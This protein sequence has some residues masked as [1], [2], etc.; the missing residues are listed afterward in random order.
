MIQNGIARTQWLA[1]AALTGLLASCAAGPHAV[2]PPVTGNPPVVA[3]QTGPISYKSS[4][5]AGM[6]A[7]RADFSNRALEAGHDRAL[8]ESLLTGIEPIP[9]WLARQSSRLPPSAWATRLSS[10]SRSGII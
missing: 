3:P 5:H 9:L 4:G 1:A 10:P 8:V 6:D 7:W 2:K